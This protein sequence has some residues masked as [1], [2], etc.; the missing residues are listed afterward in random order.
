MMSPPSLLVMTSIVKSFPGVLALDDVS[1]SVAAGEI[2]GL[3][4]E[5]GA[6]KSTI[7]KVLAG[8]YTPDSG[9]V[10]LDGARLD[11]TNSREVFA[12]GIRF[13][14]QELH[15]VPHFTIVES[16]FMG[17]ELSTSLGLDVREMKERAVAILKN[18]L[19][20]DLDPHALVRDLSP[21]ERKLV[22]IARALVV[23]GAKLVVFDEPTAPLASTEVEKVLSA[24]R[25][26]KDQ[27]IS[28]IYVSHYLAEIAELCDRVTVLRNGKNAGNLD[29]PTASSIPELIR[30]IV[31]RELEDMFPPRNSSL[32]SEVLRLEDFGDRKRFSNISLS[33]KS[34]EIVGL[35]G[36][37]GAG[38]EEIVD[39]LMG[40]RNAKEGTVFLREKKVKFRSPSAALRQGMVLIPRDRRNDGL[41]LD[42][43]VTHNITLSTL[44]DVSRAGLVSRKKSRDRAT[45]MISALDI[46]PQDPTRK[47][48]LL[49]GGN[50]Q[51]VV[52]ARSLAAKAKMF[53]FDEPTVGV[54]VGAKSEIYKIVRDLA[55][56]GAAILVSSNEPAELLGLCDRVLVIVRG[57][58]VSEH[59]S[60]EANRDQLVEAM[61]GGSVS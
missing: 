15:L 17:Q 3:V 26:L 51:K 14:H 18:G 22:Q 31:G 10:E 7:I 40:L 45:H 13:V 11:T 36:V 12:R 23:E 9:S 48:R 43:S 24:I 46:R 38:C 19:G 6:G 41:V 34:G 1:L 32:G 44:S 42:M 29:S 56:N 27:G 33:V 35:A 37:L 60:H 50:Q 28:V 58:V 55:T 8:V 2:H 30:M 20:V 54:D 53:V 39:A 57:R 5:N 25:R 49:S 61:T 21:A 4:G 47:A 16:I 52:L 59:N